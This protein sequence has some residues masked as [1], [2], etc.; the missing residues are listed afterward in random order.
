MSQLGQMPK[1]RMSAQLGILG[2]FPSSGRGPY[3]LA[4]HAEAAAPYGYGPKSPDR[5]RSQVAS[6]SR[7]SHCRQRTRRLPARLKSADHGQRRASLR[8]LARTRSHGLNIIFR[9]YNGRCIRPRS[10]PMPRPLRRR[11]KAAFRWSWEATY[12]AAVSRAASAACPYRS[13]AVPLA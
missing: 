12:P 3:L 4:S 6:L 5:D 13:C 7:Q 9:G 10:Q 1:R 2:N 11:Y 8:L